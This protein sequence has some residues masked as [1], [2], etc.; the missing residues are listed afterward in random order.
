[1]GMKPRLTGSERIRGTLEGGSGQR[2]PARGG[3]CFSFSVMGAIAACLN[4]DGTIEK[5]THS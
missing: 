4:M 5:E 3:F 2:I 1:V